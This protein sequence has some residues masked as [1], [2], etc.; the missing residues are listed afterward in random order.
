MAYTI[1]KAMLKQVRMAAGNLDD[2]LIHL[3]RVR[4]TFEKEHP[5]LTQCVDL[6]SA[7][8]IK[9]QRVINELLDLF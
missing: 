3:L 2:A 6:V 9:T 1:R 4:N 8:V 5:E 7:E